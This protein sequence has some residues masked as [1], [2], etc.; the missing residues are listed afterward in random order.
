MFFLAC[1]RKGE[2]AVNRK[3][4]PERGRGRGRGRER[5]GRKGR[6]RKRGRG[7]EEFLFFCQ[8]SHIAVNLI[9][10]KTWGILY[11]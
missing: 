10:F 6:G 11:E 4:L 9:Y 7:E 1:H 3:R 2:P 5:R 8:V